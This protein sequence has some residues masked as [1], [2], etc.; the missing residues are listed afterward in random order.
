L[1]F[2]FAEANGTLLADGRAELT[3]VGVKSIRVSPDGAHLATGSRDGNIRCV[4]MLFL[5]KFWV[6]KCVF[7]TVNCSI[8]PPVNSL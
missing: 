5:F 6:F 2:D 8:P 4:D 3:N 7:R 1:S